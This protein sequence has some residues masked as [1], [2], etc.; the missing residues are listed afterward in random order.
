MPNINEE[1]TYLLLFGIFANTSNHC[2]ICLPKMCIPG[3][4]S[5]LPS[6]CGPKK[7][8][9]KDVIEKVTFRPAWCFYLSCPHEQT[10][11]KRLPLPEWLS[12]VVST[13]DNCHRKLQLHLPSQLKPHERYSYIMWAEDRTAAGWFRWMLFSGFILTDAAGWWGF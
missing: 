4:V 3:P 2:Q 13:P 5:E 10:L 8:S 1:M 6:E 7:S 9:R 12:A 11:R